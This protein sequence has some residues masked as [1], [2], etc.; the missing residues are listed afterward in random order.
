MKHRFLCLYFFSALTMA[1]NNNKT[2]DDTAAIVDSS[3][4]ATP[5]EP[6]NNSLCYAYTNNKDSILLHLTTEGNKVTG[7]MVYSLFEK[8]KNTGTIE[9]EIKGDTIFMNY[10]F[11][12]EGISSIREI[13]FLKKGN[14]LSEGFGEVEQQDNKTVFK[15]KSLLSFSQNIVLQQTPCEQ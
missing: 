5:G 15:N 3:A 10:T 1:C 9:G 14:T 6:A 4:A 2:A 11:L 12:S 8:D 13:A 7:N